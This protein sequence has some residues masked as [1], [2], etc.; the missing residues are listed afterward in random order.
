MKFEING[1]ERD[2]LQFQWQVQIFSLN[3]SISDLIEYCSGSNQTNRRCHVRNDH[4]N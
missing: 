3:K 2:A 1:K 4:K